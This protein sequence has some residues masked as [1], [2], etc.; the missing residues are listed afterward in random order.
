MYKPQFAKTNRPVT[1]AERINLFRSLKQKQIE[2]QVKGND[3]F[4]SRHNQVLKSTASAHK[5]KV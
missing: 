3:A 2:T 4:I 1:A 5:L